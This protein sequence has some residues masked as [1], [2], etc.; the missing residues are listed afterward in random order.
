MK[1][2]HLDRFSRD[3]RPAVLAYL[4]YPDEEHLAAAYEL[5]RSALAA[6]ITLL[7]LVR[8]HHAVVGDVLRTTNSDEMPTSV[9]AAAEFLVEA[10]A[11]FEIARRGFLESTGAGPASPGAPQA[12]P[13][14]P[15]QRRNK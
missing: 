6:D 11:P 15:R 5:G 4:G 12:A 3:Y 14:A 1:S 8:V 9:D 7:D 2:N 13:P 10:L